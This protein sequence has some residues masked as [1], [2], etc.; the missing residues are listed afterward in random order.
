MM[1]ATVSGNPMIKNYVIVI[2]G[3]W[4]VAWVQISEGYCNYSNLVIV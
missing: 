4:G 1:A 3:K 2:D